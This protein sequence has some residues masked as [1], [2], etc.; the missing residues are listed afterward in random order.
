MCGIPV[1]HSLGYMDDKN[2]RMYM[3]NIFDEFS[4]VISVQSDTLNG[5]TGNKKVIKNNNIFLPILNSP[6]YHSIK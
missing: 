5:D 3:K 4:I 6:G 1:T 2:R